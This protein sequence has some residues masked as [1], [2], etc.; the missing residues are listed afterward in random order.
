MTA[1]IASVPAPVGASRVRIAISSP[2]ILARIRQVFAAKGLAVEIDRLPYVEVT[3]SRTAGAAPAD[4]SA[5]GDAVHRLAGPVP[6]ANAAPSRRLCAEYQLSV[7][8]A[9]DQPRADNRLMAGRRGLAVV[10]DLDAGDPVGTLSQRQRE[11]MDLVSRG[12]RN[13]E[14]AARLQVSEKTVKNHINQIFSKLGASSRVEAVLI[15]QRYREQSYQEQHLQEPGPEENA[16]G[17][18]G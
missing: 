1:A 2:D 7:V 13:A 4:P 9:G 3:V 12:V 6:R 5:I 11:V 10:P 17:L 14:I 18:A 16:A 15:W 8:G